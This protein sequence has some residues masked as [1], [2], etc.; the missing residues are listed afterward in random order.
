MKC[1]RL[2]FLEEECNFKYIFVS[3]YKYFNLPEFPET[4]LILFS[5]DTDFQ[6]AFRPIERI[7]DPGLICRHFQYSSL[8]TTISQKACFQTG[9]ELRVSFY[10]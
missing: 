7:P 1:T 5:C 10:F 8:V 4:N 2:Q 3:V 9:S 6:R